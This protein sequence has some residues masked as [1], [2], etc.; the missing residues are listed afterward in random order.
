MQTTFLITLQRLK[1]HVQDSGADGATLS[2][3]ELSR[4]LT[5]QGSGRVLLQW[6]ADTA[7]QM[8]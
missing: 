6:K 1:I 5:N 8:V 7:K 2:G 3:V 4:P